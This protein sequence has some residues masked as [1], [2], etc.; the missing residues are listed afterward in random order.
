MVLENLLSYQ[1]IHTC[2]QTKKVRQC[3]KNTF[4]SIK[5]YYLKQQGSN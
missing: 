5:T 1:D 3:L 2:L 4:T